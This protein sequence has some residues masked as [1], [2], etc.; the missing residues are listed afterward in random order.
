MAGMNWNKAGNGVERNMKDLALV[1]KALRENC[2]ECEFLLIG[3]GSE[4]EKVGDAEVREAYAALSSLAEKKDYFVVTTVTDARIFDSSLDAKRI[5]APCGNV[6]W[7]QCSRACTK[8]IWEKGELEREICPHCGMPLTANTIKA[9]PYIEEGYLPQWQ[10]YREWLAKTLNHRLLVLELG[11]DFKTPT[12][13]RWPFEKTVFFNQKAHM[14]R[15]NRKFYQIAG[16]IVDRAVPVEA[17]SVDFMRNLGAN[18]C[19]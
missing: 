13:I 10:A 16:E 7:L 2:R 11:V 15:I 6:N 17:N 18:D 4:W 3:L 8:D 12:V 14:Y 1:R 5:T 9:D 19:E